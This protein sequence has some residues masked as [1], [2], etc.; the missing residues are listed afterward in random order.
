MVLTEAA[1]VG[2][3]LPGVPTH[4]PKLGE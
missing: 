1:D 4:S 3:L 2:F